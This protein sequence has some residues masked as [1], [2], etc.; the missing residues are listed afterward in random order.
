[1]RATRLPAMNASSQHVAAGHCSSDLPACKT[2]RRRAGYH[3]TANLHHPTSSTFLRRARQA[4]EHVEIRWSSRFSIYLRLCQTSVW[5]MR[6]TMNR[7]L[8]P[9]RLILSLH[10]K[11]MAPPVVNVCTQSHDQHDPC[12]P[13]SG[14]VSRN[15]QHKP[16]FFQG[17]AAISAIGHTAAL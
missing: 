13:P 8:L 10:C 14:C 1:M 16:F 7:C 5:A 15:S 11:I 9:Q 12:Y 4:G 6:H 3:A 2:I 17:P